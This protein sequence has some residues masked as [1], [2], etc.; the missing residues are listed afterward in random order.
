[1]EAPPPA[2]TVKMDADGYLHQEICPNL[3][4][5]FG[6]L[7]AGDFPLWHD[8]SLCGMPFFANPEHGLLQPLNAPFL[9]MTVPR[10]LALHAFIALALMGF[11]FSLFMRAMHVRYISA[12]FGGVI[13]VFCG[14]TAA[15]LSRPAFLNALVWFPLLCWALREYAAKK[16][17]PSLVVG[18]AATALLILSGSFLLTAT[19]A[20]YCLVY[21][22]GLIL[23]VVPSSSDAPPLEPHRR[24]TVFAGM[25]VLFTAGVLISAVQWMPALAW[26][27]TL[28]APLRYFGRLALPGLFPNTMVRLF[29]QLLQASS[30]GGPALCY[31]G[32]ASLIVIPASFFHATPRWEKMFLSGWAALMVLIPFWTG[33]MDAGNM[34]GYAVFLFPA[35]FSLSVLAA[36]GVDR[37]F[38]P[39]RTRHTPRFW[40]PLVLVAVFF[41][42]IFFI[43][44]APVKGRMIPIMVA[45]AFFCVFR[46]YWSG[47]ISSLALA[48][49]LFVDLNTAPTH[50]YLHPYFAGTSAAQTHSD[51][52][53]LMQK[54][55]LDG[56]YWVSAHPLDPE[57]HANRGWEEGMRCAG[58]VGAPLT[59]KQAAWWN[60]L[61]SGSIEDEGLERYVSGDVHADSEWAGLLNIMAVRAI[62]VTP[63][64]NLAAGSAPGL[65]LRNRGNE[66]RV[67]VYEN[68]NALPRIYWASSWRMVLDMPSAVAALCE[69]DFQARGECVVAPNEPGISHLVRT[70]AGDRSG[71]AKQ[72]ENVPTILS[73]HDDP[74]CQIYETTSA[75][76]GILVVHDSYAPGWRVKVDDAP[77]PLL[78]VNGLFRGVALSAG[79]HQV[80][81]QYR[82]RSVM[83]G[84]TVSLT[85][86][87]ALL[88]G[89]LL[90]AV[91]PRLNIG[92]RMPRGKA[93]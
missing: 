21:A 40:G 79:T 5:G 20:G 42:A 72:A 87:C 37:M 33:M 77:A 52:A 71:E 63:E 54:T 80:V 73:L 11:F 89:M 65:R 16:T 29:S 88:L 90:A 39:R 8:R 2:R 43:A 61:R 67:V 81:F 17:F 47:S 60:A 59:A 46:T 70:V 24:W 91:Y 78:E 48:L 92:K 69:A 34:P 41:L 26:A 66:D 4:Y 55:A 15:S 57:M 76:P 62:A 10:A 22:L 18:G 23:F 1:M 58:A 93:F 6:R 30:E 84:A 45:V 35:V 3:A 13:Y 7:R 49:F 50:S 75:A 68:E 82:P 28:E 27:F 36:L 74:E 53:S 19:L 14:M 56:R 64:G 9:F 31:A 12:L 44:P 38:T 83:L 86:V 51:V 25:S 85:S 32:I